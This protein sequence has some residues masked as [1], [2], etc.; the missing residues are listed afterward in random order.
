[1]T[2]IYLSLSAQLAKSTFYMKS[3]VYLDFFFYFFFFLILGGLYHLSL[4]VWPS[5]LK[6]RGYFTNEKDGEGAIPFFSARING[7]GLIFQG[8]NIL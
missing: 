8:A 2:T 6:G 4:M 3:P 7:N 5:T 1:M